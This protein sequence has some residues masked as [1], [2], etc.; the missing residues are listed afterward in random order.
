M[1]GN[2]VHKCICGAELIQKAAAKIYI[3]SAV[4]CDVCHRMNQLGINDQFWHCKQGKNMYHKDGFDVCNICVEDYDA[5]SVIECNQFALPIVNHKTCINTDGISNCPQFTELQNVCSKKVRNTM[6]MQRIVNN[7]LHILHAHNT[8]KDLQEIQKG[9]NKCNA[10]NCESFAR[11]HRIRGEEQKQDV[12]YEIMDEIHDRIH[13]Y[14][15]H[16]DL[17]VNKM[18]KSIYSDHRLKQR[19]TKVFE[20]FEYKNGAFNV[21]HEFRYEYSEEMYTE[22][23]VCVS[24]KFTSLKEELTSNDIYRINMGQFNNE[25]IKARLHYDSEYRK[26][27]ITTNSLDKQWRFLMQHVIVLQI[28]CNFTDLQYAFSKTYRE[29]DGK[30]HRNYY[31]MGMYLKM[32]AKRFGTPVINGTINK[33]Y[34]GLSEKL[35]F[36]DYFS[37]AKF[38]GISIKC[39]LS[40]TSSFAVASNFASDNGLI[41]EFGA[42]SYLQNKYFSVSWLSDFPYEHEYLF[43]QNEGHFRMNNIFDVQMGFEYVHL[44]RALTVLKYLISKCQFKYH[45][46]MD[47]LTDKSRLCLELIFNHKLAKFGKY[48]Q[49]LVQNFLEKQESVYI[50]FDVIKDAS[51]LD[52]FCNIDNHGNICI[53]IATMKTLFVNMTTLSICNIH[54]LDSKLVRKAGTSKRQQMETSH[55]ISHKLNDCDQHSD[56]IS[57]R[58]QD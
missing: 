30:K 51:L 41:I 38:E 6:N 52:L 58:A 23:S 27:A 12:E 46:M 36:T 4:A 37:G 47:K 54:R 43:I 55:S 14:F 25:C 40:T 21:G 26:K 32:V 35:L 2:S 29:N 15:S 10:S 8:Q 39:P 11:F 5:K 42:I 45:M 22:D 53:A 33:F 20:Q 57:N 48:G 13:C 34:H 44:L 19:Y 16:S 1:N 31:F 7:F 3:A 9:Q 49:K 50:D 18:E 28:Y 56:A 17:S 24:P